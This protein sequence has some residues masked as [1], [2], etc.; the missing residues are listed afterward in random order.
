MFFTGNNPN[1]L[2]DSHASADFDRTNVFSAN[3]QAAVPNLVKNHSLLSY[4]TNGWNVTGIGILQSG[5][6]YSLYE[7]YGAVGSIYYGNFPTLSNPVLPI[8]DPSRPHS[9]LTGHTGSFRDG[10]NY[11]PAIDPTQI[12]L[13]YL[14][15]GQKGI[16]TCA[17]NEPCDVYETDFAPS[18]QRNIFRQS[19]QKR[20]DMSLR[21]VFKVSERFALQYEFNVFNLTNHTSLD[22]PQ[23]QTE[24]G[25]NEAC[26]PNLQSL[27]D[28]FAVNFGQVLT[29]K[30]EEGAIRQGDGSNPNV[31]PLYL[32]PHTVGSGSGVEVT[33][34][35]FGSVTNTIGSARVITMG[36]HIT[37]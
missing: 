17:T 35:N 37:Y 31:N 29:T 1:N 6:P 9:A 11:I 30:G 10:T 32:L 4:V 25:Q 23:D 20:L 7:F 15:P 18:N 12:A 2:R 8:K 3:F 19:A 28:D 33:N 26:N 34:S 14:S 16:P 13:N 24:I 5:E 21:K 36:I 22:V 27:C